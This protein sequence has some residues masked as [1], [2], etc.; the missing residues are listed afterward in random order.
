MRKS[1]EIKKREIP[2]TNEQGAEVLELTDQM[3][4]KYTSKAPH[5]TRDEL[6]EE[7]IFT[8]MKIYSKYGFEPNLMKRAC[9]TRM[10][11]L[12]RYNKNKP[13]YNVDSLEELDSLISS[14][15]SESSSESTGGIPSTRRLESEAI[16]N[17]I[18]DNLI[19][20]LRKVF[21]DTSS[22]DRAYVDLVLELEG[23]VSPDKNFD[24]ET[25]AGASYKKND[26]AQA[27][28]F[29]SSSATPFKYCRTRIQ[30][31]CAYYLYVKGYKMY[32]K[33]YGWTD[34]WVPD[35]LNITRSKRVISKCK[36]VLGLDE[37]FELDLSDMLA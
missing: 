25:F 24:F 35:Y 6:R 31:A 11:D 23:S 9:H 7:F 17:Q 34:P 2:M 33:D 13:S 15:N 30:V 36:Q 3:A 5:L 37:D 22:V 26:I 8:C 27:L 1:N 20:Y 14:N 32:L 4:W 12:V 19:S 10:V 28:G 29:S 16:G 18:A 21:D